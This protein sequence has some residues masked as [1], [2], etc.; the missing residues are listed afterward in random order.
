MRRTAVWIARLREGAK[1]RRRDLR[2]LAAM[3]V[4]AL[5]VVLLIGGG[6]L[7]PPSA[8]SAAP[9]APINTTLFLWPAGAPQFDYPSGGS[10]RTVVVA[11]LGTGRHSVRRLPGIAPGDFPVPLLAVSDH[12]VYNGGRGVSAV[13]STLEGGVRVLGRATYFV[14]SARVDQILLV[15]AGAKPG[16]AIQIQPVSVSSRRQSAKTVLPRGAGIVRGTDAGLLLISPSGDLEL[17]RAGHPA[18]KL[19]HLGTTSADAGFASDPRRV[20]YATGCRIEEATSGF[21]RTP[22]G[23]DVCSML[24]VVDVV[25]GRRRSYSAPPKTVG[26]VPNGFGLN[27][28]L[29]PKGDMLAVEAAIPPVRKGRIRLF[30]VPI[31][32]DRRAP[33]PVPSSTARLYARTAWSPDGA[34]LLYQG[35]R[36]RL[37]TFR[38][39]TGAQHQSTLLCCKYTAMVAIRGTR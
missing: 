12:L 3:A 27:N 13:A 22:V 37:S 26:W 33:I 28:G 35:P 4:A 23:Y 32:G 20:A 11:D 38:P 18:R 39:A 19:A 1:P 21:P 16:K 6:A 7:L 5:A 31:G 36:G 30:A 9:S 34:W 24:H 8:A 25:T 29:A 17:W 14:P 2:W 15:R 10:G